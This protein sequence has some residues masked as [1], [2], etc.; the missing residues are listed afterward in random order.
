[1]ASLSTGSVLKRADPSTIHGKFLVG[2]QGWYTCAGDAYVDSLALTH[3]GWLHWFNR[4]I[5]DGGHPNIDLWPDLWSSFA[6]YTPTEMFRVPGLKRTD[7]VS[8]MLFSS[9]DRK[10]V[11]RHFHWMAVYGVDGAFLQ[12]AMGETDLEL[13]NEALR[14]LRDEVG[15]KVMESAEK[16]GRVFAIMYDVSGVAPD[17]LQR[18][19]EQDWMHLIRD[20]AVLDSR[21]YL[22]EQGRPVVA[23]K[24]F[25]LSDAQHSPSMVRAVA[26]FMRDNTPGGAYI[27][28]GVPAHWRTSAMDVDPDP[29][30]MRV[31]L[32]EFD[33]ISPWTVG[34]YRNEGEADRFEQETIKGD[35]ELIKQHNEL[36]ERIPGSMRTIDYIPVIFPGRSAHNLSEGR[37]GWNDCP[38][39][40]GHFMWRQL[41]NLRRHSVRTVF[42]RRYSVRTIFGA[43]WDGYDEGTALM[44]VVSSERR[45]PVHEKYRFMALEEEDM[46]EDWYMR[47]CGF[48][49]EGLH[50]GRVIG[51]KFPSDELQGYWST[52]HRRL[53]DLNVHFD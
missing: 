29:E 48:A 17:R 21:A 11:R 15:D 25:S 13:G 24:G 31:W 46:D 19:L 18:V 4:P 5:P 40:G 42:G 38:R 35:L 44:P 36:A 49:A 22:R 28:A 10:T 37:L 16:E 39:K 9:R 34:E 33:A 27:V 43:M 26:R 41:F 52:G 51:E 53:A 7:G 14:N 23:L 32:G 20:K 8:V 45:L 3:K 6:N 2:Y 30:F 50:G 1:M 47:I 12:R